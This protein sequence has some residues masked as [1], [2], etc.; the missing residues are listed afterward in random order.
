[1]AIFQIFFT[2]SS[3]RCS[4][5][6]CFRRIFCRTSVHKSCSLHRS[7]FFSH[8]RKICRTTRS[9]LIFKWFIPVVCDYIIKYQNDIRWVSQN[10][11][12]YYGV[13]C[14]KI[15]NMFRPFSISS[16]CQ[17]WWWH[18][19]KGPKYVVYLLT[20]YTVIKC[21]FDSSTWYHFD[22]WYCSALMFT[23]PINCTCIV[24]SNISVCV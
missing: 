14:Q 9:S 4:I 8:K 19:R 15:D 12:L 7:A 3:L 10:T 11:T 1:M 22:I 16:P 21:C 20:P 13:R 18:Y 23:K 5:Y 17:T 24:Y 6:L 2:F